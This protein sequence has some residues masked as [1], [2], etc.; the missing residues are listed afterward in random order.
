M[1]SYVV[2]LKEYVLDIIIFKAIDYSYIRAI[3][4]SFFNSL[5]VR[6]N[7]IY[8]IFANNRKIIIYI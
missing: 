5:H 3:L 6:Y 7:F 4:F 8:I 2:K 1:C